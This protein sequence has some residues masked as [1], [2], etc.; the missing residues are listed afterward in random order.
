M[1]SG[2]S[3][4]DQREIPILDEHTFGDWN[5]FKEPTVESEGEEKRVCGVCGK[6]EVRLIEKLAPPEGSETPEIPEAKPKDLWWIALIVV[7]IGAV[8]ILSFV[9]INKSKKAKQ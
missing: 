8:I 5:I 1:C 4:T 3:G 7:G 2:C 9:L 6:D